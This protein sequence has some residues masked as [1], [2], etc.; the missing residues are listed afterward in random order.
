MDSQ[1][2]PL[3]EFCG[4]KGE[5]GPQ[6]GRHSNCWNIDLSSDLVEVISITD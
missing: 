2:I 1:P 4:F 3:G 6:I 5:L